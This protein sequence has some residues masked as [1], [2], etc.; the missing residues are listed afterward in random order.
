M[1]NLFLTIIILISTNSFG[2]CEDFSKEVFDI[3]KSGEYNN[4]ENYLQS[5]EQQRKILHWPDNNEANTIL[6][7]FKDSLKLSIIKSAI[8]IR[9]SN[10][11][12]NCDFDQAEFIGCK[13]TYGTNSKIEI[14]FKICDSLKSFTIQTIQTDKTYIV[15]PINYQSELL[16]E[17]NKVS[18]TIQDR[19][20]YNIFSPRKDEKEK[21][22]QILKNHLDS[23]SMTDYSALCINGLIDE[24]ENTFLEYAVYK[25]GHSGTETYLVDI[26]NKRCIKK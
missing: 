18:F 26:E 21:A 3:I 12:N 23:I 2:Q 14:S 25:K 1:K 6:K 17:F 16:E 7:S 13:R 15:L 4:F 10:S 20:K 5:I 9:N 22:L 24:N 19:V 8:D 11:A